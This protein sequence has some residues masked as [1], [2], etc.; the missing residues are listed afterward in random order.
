MKQVRFNNANN[1]DT[2]ETATASIVSTTITEPSKEAN[3]NESGCSYTDENGQPHD[4][5]SPSKANS[6]DVKTNTCEHGYNSGFNT[7]A[8]YATGYSN[9]HADGQYAMIVLND[10]PGRNWG[11]DG[12]S[13]DNNDW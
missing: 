1:D 6:S 9:G 13:Y 10:R 11:S 8:T 2:H 12:S 5:D 7:D 4:G 3:D